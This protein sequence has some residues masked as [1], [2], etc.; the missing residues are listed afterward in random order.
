MKL[1]AAVNLMTLFCI[2]E[3]YG[4]SIIANPIISRGKPTYGSSKGTAVLVDGKFN[5]PAWP[6]TMGSWVAIKV[7]KGPSKIFLNWNNPAYSWSDSIGKATSCKN[8]ME[9]PR[10]YDILISSNSTRGFDGHWTKVASVRTNTVTARGHIIDFTGASWVKM[11]ILAGGGKLDEIEVFDVSNGAQDIWFFTGTSI[12]ANTYKDALVPAQNFA[13]YIAAAHPGFHPAMIRG[14]IGCINSTT[15]AGDISKYLD[16]TRNVHFWAIEMGTNDAWG[17][18]DTGVAAF[19]KNMQVV[20]DSCKAAGIQPIIARLI[21]TDSIK[22]GWEVNPFFLKV[23]DSLTSANGLIAGPDLYS[24]FKAH[25]GDLN[26]DGVHPNANGGA[27]IQK[28]WAD[29]M[30]ILYTNG[31]SFPKQADPRDSSRLH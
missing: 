28:L 20:I 26:N 12:S 10:D 7:G 23:I 11:S 24:W 6:V 30:S 21:A 22:A 1:Y 31:A 29:K 3:I 4:Q 16:M 19:T 13:D 5:T 17:G 9:V 15:F 18:N 14:G 8:N 27:A 2:V 25:P